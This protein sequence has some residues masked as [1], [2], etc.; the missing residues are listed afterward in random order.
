MTLASNQ[1]LPPHSTSR[2]GYI[3]LSKRRVSP[4]EVAKCEEKYN[5]SKA[6]HSILRH[7]AEKHD[8]E[9]VKLYETIGWPLYRKYRH[10]YD[11]FKVAIT[12]GLCEMKT[13]DEVTRKGEARDSTYRSY[14]KVR[15][16]LLNNIKRRMTPQ[17]VKIRA[18]FDAMERALN[19]IKNTLEQYRWSRFKIEKEAKLVSETDDRDFAALMAKAEKENEMVS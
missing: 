4:E 17:P 7:V 2:S 6:V 5:K 1:A 8:M 12:M 9:L 10:A 11:A 18:R 13:W 16:E 15:E 3:D 19:E 14:Q